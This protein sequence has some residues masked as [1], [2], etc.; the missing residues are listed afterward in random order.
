MEVT[1]LLSQSEANNYVYNPSLPNIATK[2]LST[3]IQIN[4]DPQGT[5]KVFNT[6]VGFFWQTVDSDESLMDQNLNDENVQY[7]T[8][9]TMSLI[10]QRIFK[11]PRS[12][13]GILNRILQEGL[14]LVGIRLLYPTWQLLNMQNSSGISNSCHPQSDEEVINNI[15]P[16][17][18]LAMRGTFARSIWLDAVGPSDPSLARRTDPNSLCAM[19]G[20]SSREECLLFCP[21]NPMRVQSEL[22][23][24]FGGRVPQGGSIDVGTPYVSKDHTR[25]TSP[26]GRK[27]RKYIDKQDKGNDFLPSHRPPATLTATTKSHVILILSALVP[28]RALGLLLATC[29]RRGYQL[30]GLRRNKLTV[31]KAKTLGESYIKITSCKHS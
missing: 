13:M 27:G 22:V 31:K 2:P 18:A 4:P 17:L 9:N 16:V 11:D 25:S 10:Y 23:R 3:F 20:G 29:Q 28:I 5:G 14:D 12:M 26:R 15:G 21:R 6:K 1:S 7:E 24:W 30:R 19:Y 8:Q